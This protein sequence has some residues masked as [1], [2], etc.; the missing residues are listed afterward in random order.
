MLELASEAPVLRKR[1]RRLLGEDG[2][3]SATEIV[4]VI[5]P[6]LQE[7][8]NLALIGGA[9][10]D[11]ARLGVG[12]FQSD[13]D[14]VLYNGDRDAFRKLMQDLSAKPNR[15]GGY[16]IRYVRWR[17]DIW[18]LEDTWARTA[19]VRQVRHIQDLLDCTFFNWDAI[20]FDL[21][22]RAIITRPDYFDS[23]KACILDVNLEE[24]PNPT[25]SLVRALRRGALW[26][27]R[28]GSKLT[29]FVRQQFDRESWDALVA[30][31]AAAF[32]HPVL[33]HCDPRDIRERLEVELSWGQRKV[34]EPFG[35]PQNQL[36]LPL[37]RAS[38]VEATGRRQP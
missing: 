7:V 20:L 21:R 4:N 28:F 33:R 1:L 9:V 19:G 22:T 23:L 30:L 14:F 6:Q 29:S 5:L 18:A 36:V 38:G 3:K 8:G 37:Q 12:R 13:L 16:S 35:P 32:A 15:F 17:V 24:N 26:R 27:V 11:V 31:D 10:R 2:R 25:G 34:T